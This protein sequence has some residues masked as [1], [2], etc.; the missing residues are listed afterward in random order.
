MPNTITPISPGDLTLWRTA[1]Y[2]MQG[3]LY[4]DNAPIVFRAQVDLSSGT[5]YPIQDVPFKNVTIGSH[6]VLK[7]NMTVIFESSP[8]ADDRGRQRIR[9]IDGSTSQIRIGRSSQGM[10]D[11][12]VNALDNTYITV[13][14]DRR[15]AP[16]IPYID[17]DTLETF[18]DGDFDFATYGV[19]QGALV[20]VGGG[21]IWIKY[22]KP[23]ESVATLSINSAVD[24]RGVDGNIVSYAND[25]VDGTYVTGGSTTA[26]WSATFPPGRRY[27]SVAITDTNGIVTL[28]ELLVVVLKDGT[29]YV[30]IKFFKINGLNPKIVGGQT[31]QFSIYQ[32]LTGYQASGGMLVC[33]FEREFYGKTEKTLNNQ[34]DFSHIKF[35]G[36]HQTDQN[37]VQGTRQGHTRETVL[38][39]LDIN[40]RLDTIPGFSQEIGR[41]ASPLNWQQAKTANL[42]KFE[43]LNKRWLDT[44]IEFTDYI[45][46]NQGDTYAFS[47]LGC[48]EKTRYQQDEGL[49]DSAIAYHATC[50]MQG[51]LLLTPDP[52]IRGTDP[53]VIISLQEG[54]YT[55]IRY[56]GTRP[57]NYYWEQ[58]GCVLTSTT[59]VDSYTPQVKFAIAPG[60]SPGWGKQK[61]TLNQQLGTSL[62]EIKDRT[63]RRYV[64]N[65]ARFGYIEVDLSHPGDFG[66]DPAYQQWIEL[67][68]SDRSAAWLGVTWTTQKCLLVQTKIS[69]PIVKR[70]HTKKVTLV[71]E[72]RVDASNAGVEEPPIPTD[73]NPPIQ[74]PTTTVEITKSATGFSVDGSSVIAH[75]AINIGL[76]N[77][78]T[79]SPKWTLAVNG[80]THHIQQIK[81]DPFSPFIVSGSGALNVYALVTSEGL[82][83]ITDILSSSRSVVLKQSLPIQ[84]LNTPNVTCS[85]RPSTTVAG[86]VY[87]AFMASNS[88][89]APAIHLSNYGATIVHTTLTGAIADGFGMDIDNH[90]ADE[91]LVA[92]RNGSFTFAVYQILNGGA[93]TR[94]TADIG[95]TLC[96]WIQKPLTTFSGGANS[97][98]GGLECFIFI[99]AVNRHLLKTTDGG[100]TVTDI[101]PSGSGGI[102]A[103][104]SSVSSLAFTTNANVLVVVGNNAK[105]YTSLNGGATWTTGA[106]FSTDLYSATMGY[107]PTSRGGSYALYGGGGSGMFYSPNFGQSAQDATGNWTTAIGA[108]TGRFQSVIPLYRNS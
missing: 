61:N 1:P 11:G 85:L 105:I 45:G 14:D 69:Y 76:G 86:D 107:Y 94:K 72:L 42:D 44:A 4:I 87:V 15:I 8:G 26:A 34:N 37:T 70:R 24:S 16:R 100:T 38:T 104:L 64:R 102:A 84:E 28:R 57:P 74:Q 31:T 80:F 106:T 98:T 12:T 47:A 9:R 66:Y 89:D 3:L 39:C 101:T 77:G 2:N 91:M 97:S 41:K 67:T 25:I 20:C 35:V 27:I 10:E 51:R 58:G 71:L 29:A 52:Q 60:F 49:V 22:L 32:S 5:T 96:Y 23:S 59:D 82:Y 73:P 36:W 78:Y 62:D 65:N 75:D 46:A 103:I 83:Y 92:I 68:I 43:V 53:D 56:N 33:F 79:T 63:K 88:S 99:A 95:Q 13:L 40:A 81:L 30:P 90:G 50:T 93:M 54:D 48:G 18:K 6:S 19:N 55:A 21:P 17:P 108:I 7:Q